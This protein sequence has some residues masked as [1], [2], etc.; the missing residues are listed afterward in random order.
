M[1]RCSGVSRRPVS[2]LMLPVVSVGPDDS[3]P[4]SGNPYVTTASPRST[5]GASR[6][7]SAGP[8]ASGTRSTARSRPVSIRTSPACARRP[9]AL[10]TITPLQPR[11]T[12]AL[13]STRPGATTKPLPLAATLRL[14]AWPG[15]GDGASSAPSG[16]GFAAVA[17]SRTRSS[18]TMRMPTGYRP[19]PSR[20]SATPGRGAGHGGAVARH[21]RRSV[22]ESAPAWRNGRRSGLKICR[23]RRAGSSPAA[24]KVLFGH[25]APDRRQPISV[26]CH[27]RSHPGSNCIC[28][29]S[30]RGRK[31][32]LQ[33]QFLAFQPDSLSLSIT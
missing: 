29:Q 26:L 2:A 9:P 19:P 23:Q 27:T 32:V 30:R 33:S 28:S 7:T 5:A 31:C 6:N 4:V 21:G 18:G 22:S 13:V 3:R 14:P 16:G 12:C 25:W 24:G 17:S 8:N 15:G 1:V 11:T 20:P 10:R